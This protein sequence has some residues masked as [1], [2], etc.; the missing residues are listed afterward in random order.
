M[1]EAPP[2]R[3][4]LFGLPDQTGHEPGV[5]HRG[6]VHDDRF[7]RQTL[8]RRGRCPVLTIVSLKLQEEAR[9]GMALDASIF[10]ETC[11]PL[12]LQ[13]GPDHVEPGGFQGVAD[14]DQGRALP[15]SGVSFEDLDPA[16]PGRQIA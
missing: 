8:R 3:P 13:T 2:L 14:R 16:V 7:L 11:G 4:R 1:G 5:V 15:R 10:F 12:S 6:L 9:E